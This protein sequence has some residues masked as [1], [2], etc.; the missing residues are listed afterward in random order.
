MPEPET[1]MPFTH[2][3]CRSCVCYWLMGLDAECPLCHGVEHRVPASDPV[4]GPRR[5]AVWDDGEAQRAREAG[6]ARHWREF[7]NSLPS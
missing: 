4:F 1:A 5:S 6:L 3:Y 7:I 2:W